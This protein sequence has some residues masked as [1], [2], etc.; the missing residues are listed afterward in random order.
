LAEIKGLLSADKD[1]LKPIVRAILQEV[2]EAEMTEAL[3]AGKGDR[4]EGHVTQLHRAFATD[5]APRTRAATSPRTALE[6]GRSG[7]SIG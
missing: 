6:K 7:A 2:L 3:G 1:F 5:E 4:V